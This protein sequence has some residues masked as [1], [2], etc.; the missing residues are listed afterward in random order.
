MI[1]CG[2]FFLQSASESITTG[3]PFQNLFFFI[4]ITKQNNLLLL[5]FV[6]SYVPFFRWSMPQIFV[7][8]VLQRQKRFFASGACTHCF[9]PLFLHL[10]GVAKR[11][12]CKWNHWLQQQSQTYLSHFFLCCAKTIFCRF[13]YFRTT[14][15]TNANNHFVADTCACYCKRC[16]QK[17]AFAT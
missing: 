15:T 2:I 14:S 16:K 12:F 1:I 4:I 9:P 5:L 17:I 13:V 7:V 3:W 8:F 10:V 6:H 11:I